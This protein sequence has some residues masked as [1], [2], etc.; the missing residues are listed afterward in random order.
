MGK[1]KTT[2]MPSSTKLVKKGP[3][4][5]RK[6]FSLSHTSLSGFSTSPAY[7]ILQGRDLLLGATPSR[8]ELWWHNLPSQPGFPR[9]PASARGLVSAL[10]PGCSLVLICRGDGHHQ[11]RCQEGEYRCSIPCPAPGKAEQLRERR[12]S[13]A[14]EEGQACTD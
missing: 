14:E 9:A 10:Q 13:E 12:R 1:K 11:N 6:R 4:I 3:V 2:A 7:P 8:E 5:T